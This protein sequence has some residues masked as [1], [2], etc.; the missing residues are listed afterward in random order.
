MNLRER[1][2]GVQYMPSSSFLRVCKTRSL[3]AGLSTMAAR[4]ARLKPETT[5]FFIWCASNPGFPLPFV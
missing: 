4:L 1:L 2:R 3:D 5:V